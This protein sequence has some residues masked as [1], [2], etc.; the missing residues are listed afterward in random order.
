MA[1]TSCPECNGKVSTTALACPHCGAAP[2]KQKSTTR[3]AISPA[4]LSQ[5]QRPATRRTPLPAPSPSGW[6]SLRSTTK[7]M[8]V[9]GIVL[10]VLMGIGAF[11]PDPPK[12]EASKREEKTPNKQDLKEDEYEITGVVRKDSSGY[13]LDTE[14]FGR[15]MML[16]GTVKDDR[17]ATEVKM[18]M[19]ALIGKRITVI[20]RTAGD[21]LYAGWRLK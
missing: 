2:S 3:G 15:L 19:K 10:G 13:V 21:F 5:Q 1:I 12:S 11:L 14:N 7:F 16:L 9:V 6:K 18:K 8:I 17:E 20:G 4:A